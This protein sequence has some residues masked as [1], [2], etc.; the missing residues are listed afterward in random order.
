MDNK[1]MAENAATENNEVSK[2]AIQAVEAMKAAMTHQEDEET[3]YITPGVEWRKSLKNLEEE[4]E[5]ELSHYNSVIKD[6]I[7]KE[8]A[9]CKEALQKEYAEKERALAKQQED[10]I[11]QLKEEHEAE[12]EKMKKLYAEQLDEAGKAFREKAAALRKEIDQHKE[13]IEVLMLHI[14]D[15]FVVQEMQM[16]QAQEAEK[17]TETE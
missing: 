9:K 1:V 14:D 7:S 6:I 13:Q 11:A 8:K 12:L 5:K 3:V 10:E 16:K 15:P 17:T 2:E 4:V